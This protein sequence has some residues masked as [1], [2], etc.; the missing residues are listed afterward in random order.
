MIDG[1]TVARWQTED[2]LIWLK[3]SGPRYEDMVF[4][5]GRVEG[6]TA[7]LHSGEDEW[8]ITR[9]TMSYA[10]W[11]MCCQAKAGDELL[12]KVRTDPVGLAQ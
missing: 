8:Q 5:L 10:S 12:L 11:L 1:H 6:D 4:I 7:Y 2:R 9:P 3:A